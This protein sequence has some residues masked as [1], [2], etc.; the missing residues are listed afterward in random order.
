MISEA[1][2]LRILSVNTS[3][4]YQGGATGRLATIASKMLSRLNFSWADAGNMVAL[5]NFSC[6]QRISSTTFSWVLMSILLITS[7]T[8]HSSL[9]SFSTHSSFLSG[10]S[11]VSVT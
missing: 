6:H 2:N 8:G 11:T 5:G 10:C 1:K 9:W 7:I 4:S 3:L